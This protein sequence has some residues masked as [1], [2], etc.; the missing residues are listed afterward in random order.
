VIAGFDSRVSLAGDGQDFLFNVPVLGA[1]HPSEET[2]DPSLVCAF[3][4]KVS[5][6]KWNLSLHARIHTGEKPYRCN[7]CQR[8]FNQNSSLRRHRQMCET[9]THWELWKRENIIVLPRLNVTYHVWVLFVTVLHCD[10]SGFVDSVGLARRDVTGGAPTW[11]C[12]VCGKVSKSKRNLSLHQRTHTGEKPFSCQICHKAF[13]QM[14]SL[15][16]HKQH[17]HSAPPFQI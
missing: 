2:P 13:T 7:I 15:T 10:V 3:C 8:S 6:T 14:S 16:R 11:L 9:G 1:H 17:C 12:M 5:K 4:G